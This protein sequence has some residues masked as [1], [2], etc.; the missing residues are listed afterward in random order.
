VVLVVDKDP[1]VRKLV[2]GIL[3][4]VGLGC[5]EAADGESGLGIAV[6]ACVSAAIVD[7]ALPGMSGAELAWRLREG[8]SGLPVVALSV[9]LDLWD[10]DDLEDLG[11]R[12]ALPKP[13]EPGRLIRAVAHAFGR[14]PGAERQTCG[15][16]PRG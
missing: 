13:F 9:R 16:R 6:E 15:G 7:L 4:S 8:M 2:R 1:A 11:I 3:E 12:E 5:I 10:T 14:L